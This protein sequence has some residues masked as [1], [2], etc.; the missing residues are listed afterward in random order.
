MNRMKRKAVRVERPMQSF[1]DLTGE[2]LQKF[3]TRLQQKQKTS[4]HLSGGGSSSPG[5]DGSSASAVA[6]VS[7][8]AK[9]LIKM[10]PVSIEVKPNAAARRKFLLQI[11]LIYKFIRP[12]ISGIDDVF[13]KQRRHEFNPR[14]YE[15]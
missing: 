14:L 6:S 4:H 2:R 3:M 11:R 5:G 8:K 9:T 13:A 7:A 15:R 1:A 12:E 10:T